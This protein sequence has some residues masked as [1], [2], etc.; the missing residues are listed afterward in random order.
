[1]TRSTTDDRTRRVRSPIHVVPRRSIVRIR[2]IELND[3]RRR[4]RHVAPARSPKNFRRQWF[5]ERYHINITGRKFQLLLS[6]SRAN[7]SRKICRG[8]KQKRNFASV[9]SA[10]FHFQD[11]RSV[12]VSSQYRYRHSARHPR[13]SSWTHR[14]F[15]KPSFNEIFSSYMMHLT[16]FHRCVQYLR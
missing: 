2:L 6:R 15:I 8:N 12:Y 7:G 1:M 11:N 13:P 9:S 3:A 10:C 14:D 16:R 4:V 5:T